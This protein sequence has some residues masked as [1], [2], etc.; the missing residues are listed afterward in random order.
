VRKRHGSV[1][2]ATFMDVVLGDSGL[3]Q[4]D[5]AAFQSQSKREEAHVH[6]SDCNA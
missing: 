5:E 3:D 1:K 6:T 4:H 2:E